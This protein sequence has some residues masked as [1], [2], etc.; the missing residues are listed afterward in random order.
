[1]ELAPIL[2]AVLVYEKIGREKFGRVLF[3][4]FMHNT[5]TSLILRSHRITFQTG[6]K[7]QS[8]TKCR[9]GDRQA[10]PRSIHP[11]IYSQ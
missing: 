5:A 9:E 10:G 11:P 4:L 1:V 6:G 7:A 2:R 3:S 8:N